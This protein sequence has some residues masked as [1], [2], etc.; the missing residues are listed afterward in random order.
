MTHDN[1]KLLDQENQN[2]DLNELL[3]SM[4][5]EPAAAPE[6]ELP[7]LSE[8]DM[9]GEE[10]P[11]Q[12]TAPQ[13][14]PD[15]AVPAEA[16]QE[17]SPKPKRS[18]R[19]K[20]QEEPAGSETSPS[21]P[22]PGISAAEPAG[23][24]EIGAD[25]DISAL[26]GPTITEDSP[27]TDPTGI[28]GTET[29]E[30]NPALGNTS[31]P[32]EIPEAEPAD[33]ADRSSDADAPAPP[34]QAKRTPTT[35]RTS[36]PKNTEAPVLTLEARGEVETEEIRS[37]VIWHEIHNAYRTRKIL[38]GQLGGIEQ[39]DSGKTIAIVDYKGFLIIIPLKE[40]MINLGRLPSGEE[41]KELML[42]Q[43][44]ILGNMLGAEVDFLVRGID[45]KTRSVVASRRETML[46]KRQTF[47]LDTDASGMYRIYEG[48]IVQA[49]VIA[50]AEKV[51]RVEIFG[52]ECSIMARDLAWD[53]IGDAHER[54]SVGDQVL[55]R[56][57]SVR[58][59][60]VE[61]ISVRADVKSVSQNTSHD[62]LKKCRIQSKYAGKV[63]DVHKGVVYIRLSNGVNAVAHSCYDHRTPGKKDD[64]SFAV[65][66]ID[67]EHGVAVGII[68]RIIRQNL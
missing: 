50:V 30:N 13:D 6:G 68:T 65:T 36:Q 18:S 46:K 53:W 23:I 4:D 19:K 15:G 11:T 9:F 28:T 20:K 31:G 37:D 67:E 47:Y 24:A 40:M 48:R 51:I 56:I 14:A 35:R 54:F 3:G 8:A 32:E 43:N 21:D 44:K 57:L 5:R 25:G 27:E 33:T 49:R 59:E 55:V 41:Y 12:D 39:T 61:E 66:R 7:E 34:S 64:V 38:T 2:L 60:N 58:R 45:S 63:T 62:N 26:D 42:R 17:P 10:T 52:V 22:N 16:V 29:E 1:E